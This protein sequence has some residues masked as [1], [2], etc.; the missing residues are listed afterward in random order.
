MDKKI[1]PFKTYTSPSPY[2]GVVIKGRIKGV[3]LQKNI[4]IN[5]PLHRRV[6]YNYK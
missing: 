3:R 1:V 6:K 4:Q 2:S 5:L